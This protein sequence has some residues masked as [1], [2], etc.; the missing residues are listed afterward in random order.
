MTDS[1]LPGT[2]IVKKWVRKPLVWCLLITLSGPV[3]F[4]FLAVSF[5][6][7]HLKTSSPMLKFVIIFIACI[8]LICIAFLIAKILQKGSNNPWVKAHLVFLVVMGTYVATFFLDKEKEKGPPGLDVY[9]LVSYAAFALMFSSLAIKTHQH[10]LFGEIVY[11]FLGVLVI[12]LMQINP[13]LFFLGACVSY[14]LIILSSFLH[15]LLSEREDDRLE[16]RDLHLLPIQMPPLRDRLLIEM[17]PSS[18]ASATPPVTRPDTETYHLDDTDTIPLLVPPPVQFRH[19]DLVEGFKN[20]LGEL[21]NLDRELARELRQPLNDYITDRSEAVPEVLVTDRNF[22]LDRILLL[23]KPKVLDVLNRLIMNFGQIEEGI[24]NLVV[25]EYCRSRKRFFEICQTLCNRV[26]RSSSDISGKCFLQLCSELAPSLLN[27][28]DYVAKNSLKYQ[29]S[30]YLPNI[31]QVFRTQR[32]LIIPSFELL[33]SNTPFRGSLWTEAINVEERLCRA[34][35]DYFFTGLEDL[36][37]A[38]GTRVEFGDYEIHHIT[39][40]VMEHLGDAFN[41]RSTL[42]LILQDFPILNFMEGRSSL[43]AHISWMIDQLETHLEA[44]SKNRAFL[45]YD[46]YYFIKNV[47]Y[48][49]RKVRDTQLDTILGRIW[50][51]EQ[52]AKIYEYIKDYRINSWVKVLDFVKF[53]SNNMTAE[54][55]KEKLQLFNDHF[56]EMFR[57]QSLWFVPENNPDE[58]LIESL[59]FFFVLA[60]E[61][62]IERVN[63]IL[64]DQGHQNVAHSTWEISSCLRKM[65]Y[66]YS[67]EEDYDDLRLPN[68]IHHV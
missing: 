18:S 21:N 6:N 2:G 25:D 27:F 52:S 33:F 41:E 64:L 55:M 36:V 51:E 63:V 61:N 48:I 44:L 14:P 20:S 65:S 42:E 45:S 28:A 23:S 66:E 40:Q 68:L 34:I 7:H 15:E 50:L 43:S 58:K 32:H 10:E 60:Y 26:F 49:V 57:E 11:F 59:S 54:S 1:S 8:F 13:W 16:N 31:F 56:P 3:G 47:C 4:I 67:K 22:L 17:L 9:A 19:D 39:V 30:D 12:R 29:Q 37:H 38:D 5:F 53:D 35:K 46:D 62:F 24:K